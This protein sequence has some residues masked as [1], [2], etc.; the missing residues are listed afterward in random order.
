[1]EGPKE[2]QV[3]KAIKIKYTWRVP[4][5]VE[6]TPK[7]LETYPDRLVTT[8]ILVGYVGPNQ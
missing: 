8:F 5:H 1:V 4:D 2:H 3:T 6:L 7:Q